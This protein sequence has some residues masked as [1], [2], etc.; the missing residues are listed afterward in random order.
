MWGKI[1]KASNQILEHVDLEKIISIEIDPMDKIIKILCSPAAVRE[2]RGYEVAK[3]KIGTY[4]N[5]ELKYE[6]C[7]WNLNKIKLQAFT[8]ESQL[9]ESEK[10]RV[11]ADDRSSLPS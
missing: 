4:L 11:K 1:I 8:N 2:F 10:E 3:S 5:Y 7:D 9:T 6:F